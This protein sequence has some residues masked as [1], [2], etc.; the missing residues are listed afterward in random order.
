MKPPD[1]KTKKKRGDLK[2]RKDL[3]PKLSCRICKKT[4]L[5]YGSKMKICAKCLRPLPHPVK[6]YGTTDLSRMIQGIT[7]DMITRCGIEIIA[8]LTHCDVMIL[9]AIAR[10][11][12]KLAAKIVDKDGPGAYR[13][14][15]RELIERLVERPPLEA[16]AA[17][18]VAPWRHLAKLSLAGEGAGPRLQRMNRAKSRADLIRYVPRLSASMDPAEPENAYGRLAKVG[19]IRETIAMRPC[20]GMWGKGLGAPKIAEITQDTKWP[21]SRSSVSRMIRQA[22]DPFPGAV[23]VKVS[24][25]VLETWNRPMP[26]AFDESA[27]GDE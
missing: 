22:K 11:T 13:E 18:L 25:L 2:R 1:S 6:T 8:D 12:M 10:G 7:E 21:T 17:P 3:D 27:D 23:A 4:H 26:E 20:L 19:R 5:R 15:S 16:E 14:I 9:D 24:D